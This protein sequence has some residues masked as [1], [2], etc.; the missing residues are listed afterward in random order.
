MIRFSKIALFGN[1]FPYTV[2]FR[3]ET[4]LYFQLI[5]DTKG[6]GA[7]LRTAVNTIVGEMG[8]VNVK[9]CVREVVS[10]RGTFTGVAA[11]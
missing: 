8:T 4:K 7:Q 2:C 6:C 9:I 10:D 1:S 3:R 11:G 5:T